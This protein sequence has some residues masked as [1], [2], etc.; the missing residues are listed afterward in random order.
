MVPLIAPPGTWITV[1]IP[2][3]IHANGRLPSPLGGRGRVHLSDPK[4]I[5]GRGSG[6]APVPL[7]TLDNLG[8]IARPLRRRRFFRMSALS[9]FDGTL[10]A[11]HGDHG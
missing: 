11:Y 2:E 10:G 6:L 8:P 5:R 9:T 7:V 3:L 1:A 4:P